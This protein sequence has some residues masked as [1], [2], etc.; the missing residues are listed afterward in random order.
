MQK[1]LLLDTL[2]RPKKI[3]FGSRDL[4]Q[5]TGQSVEEAS[6][7]K[8]GLRLFD[9]LGQTQRLADAQ[10]NLQS[11]D[12]SAETTSIFVFNHLPSIFDQKGE[13]GYK[14]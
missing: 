3:K 5:V 11:V 7:S 1:M 9:K 2:Q 4:G 13:P 8:A 10:V 14:I 12:D 6:P